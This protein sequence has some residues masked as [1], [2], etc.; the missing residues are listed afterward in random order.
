MT[1]PNVE[2]ERA[3]T[4]PAAALATGMIVLTTILLLTATFMTLKVLGDRYKEGMLAS[5]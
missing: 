1:D 3:P 4:D 2:V 5:K